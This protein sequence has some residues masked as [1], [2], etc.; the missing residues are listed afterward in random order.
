PS[1]PPRGAAWRWRAVRRPGPGRRRRRAPGP[2]RGAAEKT[3]TRAPPF[4]DTLRKSRRRARSA[5][6]RLDAV[7]A[8]PGAVTGT[9][10]A[11]AQGAGVGRLPR[12]DGHL[13]GAPLPGAEDAGVDG[14]DG[15]GGGVGGGGRPPSGGS[16]PA[17]RPAG[18]P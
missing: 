2:G 15:Q 1:C 16:P 18:R 10:D 17:G 14:G 5:P 7:A 9:P 8:A 4:D 12:E 11:V 13:D 3:W 6:G